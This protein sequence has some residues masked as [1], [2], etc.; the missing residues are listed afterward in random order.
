MSKNSL[1]LRL[2]LSS[3]VDITPQKDIWQTFSSVSLSDSK[4][5]MSP[6]G[7]YW[8]L[9]VKEN[10]I[11]QLWSPPAVETSYYWPTTQVCFKTNNRLTVKSS[12][13]GL[14]SADPRKPPCGQ[15]RCLIAWAL[16]AWLKSYLNRWRWSWYVS[17]RVKLISPAGTAWYQF[18]CS[19]ITGRFVCFTSTKWALTPRHIPSPIPYCYV[20]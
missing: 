16:E 15:E 14:G 20:P 5:Q 11:F 1:G 3:L 18:P 4:P 12:R 8:G 9:Q 10:I 6:H 17:D 2:V 19:Q 13:P 7:R